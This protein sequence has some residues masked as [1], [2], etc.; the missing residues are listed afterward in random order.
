MPPKKAQ[1]SRKTKA[2][3]LNAVLLTP[4][5]KPSKLKHPSTPSTA[6]TYKSESSGKT[7]KSSGTTKSIEAIYK[8]FNVQSD[9]ESDDDIEDE[10]DELDDDVDDNSEVT[11]FD[12]LDIEFE[13]MKSLVNAVNH[14]F[15][16]A[17]RQ[18]LAGATHREYVT[19]ICDSQTLGNVKNFYQMTA[20]RLAGKD[21]RETV[22]E[23]GQFGNKSKPIIVNKIMHHINRYIRQNSVDV[24]SRRVVANRKDDDLYAAGLTE[25]SDEEDMDFDT[26]PFIKQETDD[27]EVDD[28]DSEGDD[29]GEDEADMMN[30]QDEDDNSLENVKYQVAKKEAKKKGSGKSD[31]KSEAK[32]NTTQGKLKNKK[33]ALK[34]PENEEDDSDVDPFVGDVVFSASLV[35]TRAIQNSSGMAFYISQG[36]KVI[37]ED[38]TLHVGVFDL[39]GD[40]FFMKPE[41]MRLGLEYIQKKKNV[42]KYHVDPK[43]KWVATMKSCPRRIAYSIGDEIMRTN[44]GNA[45]QIIYLVMEIDNSNDGTCDCVTIK[46][47]VDSIA[48]DF[49]R[50]F[51]I[52]GTPGSV[53]VGI[54]FLK[55]LED[56]GNQG[57]HS[58]FLRKYSDGTNSEQAADS[59][60][61]VFDSVFNDPGLNVFWNINLDKLL[62]NFEIKQVL[63]NHAHVSGWNDLPTSDKEACFYNSTK[64]IARLPSWNSMVRVQEY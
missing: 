21:F 2:K 8:K 28:E 13:K 60:T 33:Q 57:L 10:D 37:G 35:K 16:L 23:V 39:N 12:V 44:K 22:K 50:C 64:D 51:K 7:N 19:A 27:N 45:Q 36:I 20:M 59:I 4:K 47:L 29:N 15:P 30:E 63:M 31:H 43:M 62:P 42:T 40:A 49:K 3:P 24:D 1:K 58:F 56:I 41:F 38:K 9:S 25:A 18:E 54:S 48:K 11:G 6:S 53:G 32:T 17:K 61:A 46:E 5:R 55:Y 52:Y 34:T 14:I 26:V